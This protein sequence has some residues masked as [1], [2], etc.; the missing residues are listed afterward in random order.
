MKKAFSLME[1]MIVIII[2]GLLASLVLPNLI[3]KSEEAKQKLVCVQMQSVAQALKMFKLDNGN[4]PDTQEGLQAL[5][6]NPD[7]EKYPNY[8]SKGYFS[9]GQLPKDPWG[10]P[11]IYIKTDDGFNLISLGADGKEGGKDENRD[12]SYEDCLK[13]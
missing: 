6:K 4:Y 9:N 2:L 3:G 7:P 8:S 1:L 5:V 12:I 10:H 11:F 13:K